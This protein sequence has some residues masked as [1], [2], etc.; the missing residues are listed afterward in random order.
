M[1]SLKFRVL[2]AAMLLIVTLTLSCNQES[3][4]ARTNFLTEK[5]WR[6][7]DI[8]GD[9]LDEDEREFFILFLG[10]LAYDFDEDGT[11]ITSLAGSPFDTADW[12]F[13][14]DATELSINS[15]GETTTVDIVELNDESF[16]YDETD[17]SLNT[18]LTYYFE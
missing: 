14:D 18:V 6:F 1:Q 13:N 15:D 7:A 10:S 12:T 8:Q 11:V 17:D 5:T 3:V 4:R 16:I 9:D 2:G